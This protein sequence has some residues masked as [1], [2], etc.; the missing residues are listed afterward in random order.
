VGN[1]AVQYALDHPPESGRIAAYAGPSSYILWRDPETPVVIDGWLEHFTAGQLRA[2]FG[3][4]H[5]SR[6]D[7][8]RYV[9]RL[10]VGGVI[11][12]LPEA[13]ERLEANGFVARL[14]AEHGTYLVRRGLRIG[15][16]GRQMSGGGSGAALPSSAAST[17]AVSK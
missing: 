16:P 7:P 12:Y 1:Q 8:T 10:D 13:I 11:A 15:G 5:G 4:L 9:R 17:G 6:R 3:I 14:S 2:N